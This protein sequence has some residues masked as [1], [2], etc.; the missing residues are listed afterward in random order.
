MAQGGG[1]S[2]SPGSWKRFFIC[3]SC[4]IRPLPH[5][6]FQQ[7]FVFF[8]FHLRPAISDYYTDRG[9]NNFFSRKL[10]INIKHLSNYRDSWWKYVPQTAQGMR[11][12]PSFTIWATALLSILISFQV[13]CIYH[14]TD[15][16][17]VKLKLFS[18]QILTISWADASSDN[19]EHSI[20]LFALQQ[21]S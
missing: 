5:C 13:S 4:C 10:S 1:N 14:I 15:L 16:L 21:A 18:L 2:Q 17:Q 20:S 8:N 3:N 7:A 6:L 19:T 9:G 11:S 12:L